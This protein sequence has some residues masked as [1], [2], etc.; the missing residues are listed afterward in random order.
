MFM[1]WAHGDVV[2]FS[3]ER[4]VLLTRNVLSDCL[5]Y[6][7]SIQKHH[8]KGGVFRNTIC[9]L[10]IEFGIDCVEFR[11][12]IVEVGCVEIFLNVGDVG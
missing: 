12:E 4:A 9:S 11:V 5:K 1:C 10:V 6:G 7:K 2:S 3:R 8:R